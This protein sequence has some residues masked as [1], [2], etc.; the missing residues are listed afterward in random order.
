MHR[1]ALPVSL[2]TL[3]PV[4]T[5]PNYVYVGPNCERFYV[6]LF[7]LHCMFVLFL[8]SCHLCY[9]FLSSFSLYSTFFFLLSFFVGCFFVHLHAK[10]ESLQNRPR[11]PRSSVSWPLRHPVCWALH[12][13]GAAAAPD[14]ALADRPRRRIVIFYHHHAMVRQRRHGLQG[15]APHGPRVRR[16]L[17]DGRRATC[18]WR[19]RVIE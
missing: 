17:D 15:V 1:R 3:R 7:Y 14:A 5:R 11:A 8:L 16:R 4:M 9:L 6:C 19:C 12:G 10:D 18:D 2:L 13:G